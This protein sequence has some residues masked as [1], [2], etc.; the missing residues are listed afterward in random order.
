M[1]YINTT[2]HSNIRGGW[3][4][5][6]PQK[7]IWIKRG[8]HCRVLEPL[9]P[10]ITPSIGRAPLHF[11]GT[12]VMRER[13]TPSHHSQL[14]ASLM[15]ALFRKLTTPRSTTRGLWRR[16][17]VPWL[18]HAPALG[19]LCSWHPETSPGMHTPPPIVL[20]EGAC[21]VSTT[22]NGVQSHRCGRR[23]AGEMGLPARINTPFHCSRLT[24]FCLPA[25]STGRERGD[26]I[27]HP[28]FIS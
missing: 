24:R 22:I 19:A 3:G 1:K 11:H 6:P 15:G 10:S 18:W 8:S 25:S 23:R 26:T 16:I 13:S 5:K 14:S 4:D 27:K 7:D 21:S 12:E 20:T 17:M 2:V 9:T 28:Q